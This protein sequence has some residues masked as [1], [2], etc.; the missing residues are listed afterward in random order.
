[1]SG[2]EQREALE[3]VW[4]RKLYVEWQTTV[5]SNM[6]TEWPRIRERMARMT[7]PWRD[8]F[9]AYEAS[10]EIDQHFSRLGILRAQLSLGWDSFPL[11]TQFGGIPFQ[12][13]R[14]VTAEMTAWLLKHIGFCNALH[15]SHPHLYYPNL[16]A[17]FHDVSDVV[18]SM[19][20]AVEAP[21]EQVRVA[22]DCLTLTAD[23][24]TRHS[25]SR[26]LA[27][28]IAIGRR[29]LMRS[30]AGG[31]AGSPFFF[32]LRELQHRFPS[33]WDR[34]LTHREPQFREELY[35]FFASD[36]FFRPNRPVIIRA[37]GSIVTDIDGA[38][39]D[40]ACGTLALFQLKWQQPFGASM[41][42]R[43]SRKRNFLLES[44][45]WVEK[46]DAYI[47]SQ[48]GASLARLIGLTKDET[49]QRVRLFVIGRYFSRFSGEELDNRA[50]WGAWPTVCRLITSRCR[51]DD[52]L[53]DLFVLLQSEDVLEA[54]PSVLP[55]ETF[56]LRRITIHVSHAPR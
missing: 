8:H 44:S 13:F 35:A 10:P 40:R 7:T 34:A 2:V 21:E 45:K 25:G 27:P 9:I 54:P 5:W 12:L 28:L 53:T 6:V 42:E 24:G 16:L 4:I 23:A 19:S 39:F 1:V 43:E 18:N 31:I 49:I 30:Y 26:A 52:P 3:S 47:A 48:D 20:A 22:L 32:M 33:D 50:A 41:R 55:P 46:A 11:G 37:G 15:D 36:R 29:H 51:A 38:I 56:H 14:D 17:I